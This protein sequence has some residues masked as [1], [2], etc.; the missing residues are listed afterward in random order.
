MGP[1][2]LLIILTKKY[3]ENWKINMFLKVKQNLLFAVL[4]ITY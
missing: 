4:A 3:S 2:K 1:V